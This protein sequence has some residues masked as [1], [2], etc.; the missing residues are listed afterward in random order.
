M[1]V[2]GNLSTVSTSRISVG[3]TVGS[4]SGISNDSTG[5]GGKVIWQVGRTGS[6]GSST[7][8]SGSETSR[9][10][11]TTSGCGT[12]WTSIETS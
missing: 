5:S 2:G 11:K 9:L 3:L 12:S 4:G 1:G 6:T 10:A 7:T 8:G